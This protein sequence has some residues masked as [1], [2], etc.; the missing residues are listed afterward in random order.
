MTVR[1]H[2]RRLSGLLISAAALY[3][4]AEFAPSP[5]Y[6]VAINAFADQSGPPLRSYFLLPLDSNISTDDLEFREYAQYVHKALAARGFDRVSSMESAL[7]YVFL[8]Y[9]IGEPKEHTYSYNVPTWGQTGVSAAHTSAAVT[10]FGT[11]ATVNSSTSYTPTYGVTGYQTRTGSFTTFTRHLMLSAI[12]GEF[13][14]RTGRIKEVWRTRVVSVGQ[15]GDL[16]AVLPLMVVGSYDF[17][18]ASSGQIV[19]RSIEAESPAAKWIRKPIA[20]SNVGASAGTSSP[21]V[22]GRSSAKPKARPPTWCPEPSVVRINPAVFA[23]AQVQSRRQ[24]TSR[25]T[26]GATMRAA[27]LSIDRCATTKSSHPGRRDRPSAKSG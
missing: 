12:D 5:Q 7:V 10:S 3:G 13:Y 9:G 1:Y 4:C 27:L 26:V 25:R 17:I 19:N 23:G 14:R 15:S 20:S 6:A 18:A 21:S 24:E 11:V 2:C 16:R 22:N 8:G